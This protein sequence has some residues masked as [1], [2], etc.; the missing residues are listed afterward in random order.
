MSNTP[1]D[2]A[3]TASSNNNEGEKEFVH[4][5][6]KNDPILVKHVVCIYIALY[7]SPIFPMTLISLPLSFDTSSAKKK[8]DLSKDQ[9]E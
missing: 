5:L 3:T 8:I 1:K 2:E 6:Q 7:H 4:P 9:I